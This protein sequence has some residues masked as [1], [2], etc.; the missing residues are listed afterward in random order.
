MATGTGRAPSIRD[1]AKRAGVSHQTVSRVINKS[2]RLRPETRDRVLAAIEELG[3]RPSAAARALAHGRSGRI[4]LLIESTSHYGPVGMSR[5]IEVAARHAGYS[6]TTYSVV[7]GSS[8]SF[9]RGVAFLSSQ[10]VEAMAIIAPRLQYLES[11]V[12]VALPGAG[13]LVGSPP[14]D[15]DPA[16]ELGLQRVCVDQDRGARLAMGHLIEQGHQVIAHLSGP[17]DWFDARVRRAA[18]EK[19]L[20]SHGLQVPALVE[21][22]WS[23][24]CG[25]ESA[26]KLLTIPGLTAIF[27][28][29]DQMALGLIHA[30]ADRGLRIPEDISVVGF[31]D[32]PESG[33]FR[34]PL[35]T[36]HQDFEALGE[37]AV[38]LIL[39]K[40]GKDGADIVTRIEPELVIRASSAAI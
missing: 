39:A 25:Y 38:G 21:G 40:L 3:Y 33:H 22:D 14:V 1:V 30:L 23:A 4:G 27:A 24:D 35:T 20:T 36:V 13:V 2:P 31:D 16:E 19:M 17:L 34:P 29:N 9:R 18:W 32:I 10:D 8:D 7:P 37:A 11:L 6:S 28:G 26:E 15:G 12:G 5:G